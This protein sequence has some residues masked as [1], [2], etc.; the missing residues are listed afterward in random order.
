MFANIL[1]YFIRGLAHDGAFC[2]VLLLF[3]LFVTF[4]LISNEKKEKK[5]VGSHSK[6]EDIIIFVSN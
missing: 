5:S 4:R 6:L 1:V 3:M 2:F